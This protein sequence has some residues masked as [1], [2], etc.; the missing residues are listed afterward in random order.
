M[1]IL[2]ILVS[3]ICVLSIVN[4]IIL[5]FLASFLVRLRGFVEDVVSVMT[6]IEDEE[7]ADEVLPS[8]ELKPQSKTWD[9]KYEEELDAF[10]RRTR[11]EQGIS[12]LVNP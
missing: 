1:E 6:G 11:E 8:V 9:E 3:I 7:D 12:G 2:I 5:V 10:K 4:L